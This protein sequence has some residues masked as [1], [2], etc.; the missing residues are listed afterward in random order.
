MTATSSISPASSGTRPDGMAGYRQMRTVEA[1][2]AST[3]YDEDAYT[4]QAIDRLGRTLN[5]SQPPRA[6]VPPGY[7][8]NITV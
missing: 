7:Y 3:R 6:D 8:L 2:A 5:S 4:R 1:R